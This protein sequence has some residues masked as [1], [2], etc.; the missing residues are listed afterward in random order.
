MLKYTSII[1][2]TDSFK[3]S[4]TMDLDLDV[5]IVGGGIIG[6]MTALGLQRRGMRVTVYERAPAWHEMGVGFAFT[7]AAR[8]CMGRLDPR[9]LDALLRVGEENKHEYNRYWDG[10]TPGTKA[11]AE[12]E[13]KSL[14]FQVSARDAAFVGCLRSHLLQEMAAQLPAGVARFGKQLVSCVDDEIAGNVRLLFSDGET[15]TAD[16]GASVQTVSPNTP[17]KPG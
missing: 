8:D 15:T 16:L 10:F 12:S 11:E 14:L 7:G 1:N 2:P 13:E 9:I 4:D 5:A 6:V 17:D 3:P